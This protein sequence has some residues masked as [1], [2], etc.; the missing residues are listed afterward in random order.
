M[1][2]EKKIKVVTFSSLVLLTYNPYFFTICHYCR[3][4][5]YLCRAA[6]ML[7]KFGF[8]GQPAFLQNYY[9]SVHANDGH[10]SA[11]A[12]E[13]IIDTGKMSRDHGY[14]CCSHF[15]RFERNIYL[16]TLQVKLG[17]TSY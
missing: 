16:G 13:R 8:L 12:E 17:Q 3:Y 1:K 4:F 7:G 11:S 14:F 15:Y 6:I 9:A 2:E 10:R 5:H